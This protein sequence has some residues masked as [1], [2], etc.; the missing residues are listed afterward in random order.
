MQREEEIEEGRI[1]SYSAL[2]NESYCLA[3]NQNLRR[4]NGKMIS[5]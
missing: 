5:F 2:R 4:E 1:E 3:C